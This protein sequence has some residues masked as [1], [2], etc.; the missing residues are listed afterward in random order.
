MLMVFCFYFF[1]TQ[2]QLGSGNYI[3]TYSPI[4]VNLNSK[5]LLTSQAS[6]VLAGFDYSAVFMK[7]GTIYG[8]GS[9]SKG[10]E[11]FF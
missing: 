2:G 3:N 6:L 8:F 7:D 1:K 5:L 11:F 10:R 4:S 9:N